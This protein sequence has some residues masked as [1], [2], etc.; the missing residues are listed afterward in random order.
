MCSVCGCEK[1]MY[2]EFSYRSSLVTG[3]SIGSFFA[4]QGV[5]L[6]VVYASTIWT[7]QNNETSSA[8]ISVLIKFLVCSGFSIS[9]LLTTAYHVNFNLKSAFVQVTVGFSLLL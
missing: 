6:L 4:S 5:R 7:G 8:H 3:K 2:K 9:Y 1:R